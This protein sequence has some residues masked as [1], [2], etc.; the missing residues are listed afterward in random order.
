MT[1]VATAN[2]ALFQGATVRFG[3]IASDRCLDP[4]T[5]KNALTQR[6]R[7]VVTV[8]YAG[9]PSD[10]V[11]L[12]EEIGSTP[13]VVD[14]A[15]SLGGSLN[16]QPV[17]SLGTVSTLSFHPAKQITTGEGGACVT[18]DPGLAS[19]MRRLRNHGMTSTAGERRGLEWRYDCTHLGYNYRLSEIGAALGLSQLQRLDQI[20]Q[21][22]E[23]L[24]LGYDRMLSE[25]PGLTLPPRP[26]GR[27]SAWH[28]YVISVGDGFGYSG[29]EVIDGLRAEGI[30]ASR[31]YPAVPL[32]AF[33]RRQGFGPGTSPV[34][35]SL[36][37]TLVTL[38]L[39][40]S[41]TDSDQ[42][43]VVTAITRLYD[44]RQRSPS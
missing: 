18:D 44:W 4:D 8:D 34:G 33:Y 29:D 15:H 21:R 1:F 11:A 22:R 9:M 19:D 25:L 36:I 23:E 13:L 35:E 40:P 26:L 27:R 30:E 39:F 16:G 42:Q 7:A 6:T 17:G 20:V 31:H 14:A 10:T 24:A 2:A 28:L 3:D 38:P 32:L 12:A 43:D 41:M 37:P 5:A